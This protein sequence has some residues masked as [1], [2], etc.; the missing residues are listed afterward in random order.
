MGRRVSAETITDITAAPGF[1]D[2]SKILFA[3]SAETLVQRIRKALHRKVE[4]A[5]AYPERM[6]MDKAVRNQRRFEDVLKNVPEGFRLV[7]VLYAKVGHEAHV[8][9]QNEF[10]SSTREKFM[11]FL[12]QR[13]ASDLKKLGICD[14]GIAC[15]RE[16]HAPADQAG[17]VYDVSVD[18]IIERSGAGLWGE[19]QEADPECPFK[20][21]PKFLPNHFSNLILLPEKIHSFKNELNELQGVTH[22]TPG[23]RQWILMLVPER[24]T[25]PFV[26]PPQ[27]PESPWHSLSYKPDSAESKIIRASFLADQALKAV[28]AFHRNALTD[29][30]LKTVG[31]IAR[32][33]RRSVAKAA[34]DNGRGRSLKEIFDDA[35]AYDP[36]AK[37][38]ADKQIKP[39]LEQMETSLKAAFN[40]AARG[41]RRGVKNFDRF[42]DGKKM[43]S[44]YNSISRL[45][46]DE[47][48]KL[49]MA[50]DRIDDRI[51]KMRQSWGRSG[52]N[53]PPRR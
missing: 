28:E 31:E 35:I 17:R 13:H 39:A 25:S 7:P 12:A 11:R 46:F 40:D 49:C 1:A 5:H 15:M 32:R 42:F 38:L 30:A 45:P 22:M 24:K 4:T 16:G 37:A 43:H 20:S 26:C 19:K 52:G 34:N 48:S 33:Q 51:K 23:D 50:Y 47:A 6:D 3:P 36:K 29:S 8:R 27:K 44:L 10:F 18:H 53:T 14:H 2:P 21:G 9:M 41:D